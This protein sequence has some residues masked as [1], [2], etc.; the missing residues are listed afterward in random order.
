MAVTQ[1]LAQQNTDYLQLLSGRGL[2]IAN[3]VEAEHYLSNI[4]YFRLSPYM[5]PFQLDG[6][7]SSLQFIP[8]TDFTQIVDLYVF[9]RK[10]RLLLRDPIECI[11]IALK[12]QLIRTLRAN[13]G[14]DCLADSQLFKDDYDYYWLIGTLEKLGARPKEAFLKQFRSLVPELALPPIWLAM[15]SLSFQEV[16]LLFAAL[17]QPEDKHAIVGHFG[18]PMPVLISWFRALSDLRNLCDHH[19]RV[20]NREFGSRPK[21][22]HTRH[23]PLDW[24]DTKLSLHFEGMEI[25]A[26]TRD[27]RLVMLLIIIEALLRNI[28]PDNRWKG[29]LKKHLA[30]RSTHQLMA[31]GL[32]ADWSDQGYWQP[33]P[34]KT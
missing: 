25:S 9:D 23:L 13:H 29:R 34:A 16:S 2:E 11:E 5:P 7:R 18:W 6:G 3:Q 12:T 10:L 14:V 17:R 8:G 33:Q 27:S 19:C 28:C 22:P 21:T 26:K 31:M 20:W 24:P 4:D 32:E 15:E 30:S 1:H